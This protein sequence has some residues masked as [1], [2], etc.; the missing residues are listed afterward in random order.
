M[1]TENCAN[2]LIGLLLSLSVHNPGAPMVCFVDA[3]TKKK[4]ESLSAPLRLQLHL[5][6]ELGP[7]A[8]KNRQQ[9]EAEGIFKRFTI[10]KADVIE[11]AL[12]LYPDTLFLDSDILV[13]APIEDI[14][15]TKQLGLSPHY[16]RKRDTEKYG[17]Y[18]AG[19]LWTNS[20]SLPNKWRELVPSSRF[21]EQA[22][23]E[24]LPEF[25]STFEFP[26]QYNM[27]WWRLHQA[28]EPPQ[29]VASYFTA[30]KGRIF[31]KGQPIRFIHTHFVTSKIDVYIETFNS[32]MKQLMTA[33]HMYKE[34][35]IICRIANDKWRIH[36]PKQPLP[37]P[38]EHPNDS[39]REHTLLLYKKNADV[40]IVHDNVYNLVL[41]P[42]VMLYDRDT[43]RWFVPQTM[44]GI[45]KVY[46]GN[47]NMEGDALAVRQAG[48]EVSPWIYWPRRPAFVEHL[49][50]KGVGG[51]GFTERGIESLFIGNFEN[52]V[53]QQYRTSDNWNAYVQEFHLTGG[54]KHKFTPVQYLEKLADARFGLCL[55][56]YGV[57]CHREVELM[58]F[59]TVPIVTPHVNTTAYQEPLVEGKHYV[60]VET[61]EEIPRVLASVTPE[62]WSTMSAAC[63][64]WYMRNV[65][66]DSMWRT[67]MGRLLYDE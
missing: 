40:D 49:L 43:M 20:K 41:E 23:M 9:M 24:Q 11:R 26:I 19:V 47:C 58:A 56:G 4:I 31:Y 22:C 35:T 36:V 2:E 62:Q 46:L 52:A 63:K 57:K 34:L 61:P 7:Y 55:R 10:V 18:N 3:G 66:S 1:A 29:K 39:F 13:C 21:F 30:E 42:S 38:W 17:H 33:A 12:E 59:G 5:F 6:E 54:T 37:Y 44:Q 60:R 25:F 50:G 53:Q 27:S 32:L 64:D 16:I 14:D 51:K 65:H 15:H 45:T 8:G 28:D 67:F 48:F